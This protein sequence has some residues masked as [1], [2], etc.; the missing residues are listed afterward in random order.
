MTLTL[1]HKPSD[2]P[3]I[4][5]PC[6]VQRLSLHHYRSYTDSHMELDAR[7]V[8]LC[9]PNGIGKTNALEALSLFT[10]GRGMR[11]SAFSEVA[12]TGSAGDWAVAIRLMSAGLP[13][14]L[15]TGTREA[16]TDRRLVRID[17]AQAATAAL[18]DQ[19]AMLWLTPA[20]DR[21]FVEGASGRRRFLDRL[22][23][24]LHPDHASHVG[25]YET[26]MRER[27]RLLVDAREGGPAADPAWLAALE[28]KMA[29]YALAIAAAR[30][31]TVAALQALIAHQPES[32]FP[33]AGL[34]LAGDV[35]AWLD[36]MAAIDAEDKLRAA[37]HASRAADAG[38]GRALVGVHRTDLQVWHQPKQAPAERCSTGE[39]KALLVGLILAQSQLVAARTGRRPILLLDEIAAHLDEQRRAALYAMLTG[40][41]LQ[42]WLTG[43]DASLF[44]PLGTQA[45][46]VTVQDGQLQ[47]L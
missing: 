6:W 42:A 13:V 45:Q 33:A 2:T 40:Q 19:V 7:P 23:L 26:A 9:G 3:V 12:Q 35:E 37:F 29:E 31:E 30:R 10:P 38:A 34:A 17:G 28:T 4:A 41:G 32:A 8:V 11:G 46:F 20:M 47:R 15:G 43:T 14:E 24:A 22:V 36:S 25:S 1:A 27:T 21:I 18:G 44:Q 39:Q 5:A 16:G